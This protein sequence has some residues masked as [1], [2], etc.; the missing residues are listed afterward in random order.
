M[1]LRHAQHTS[2]KRRPR[3]L[4]PSGQRCACVHR[5]ASTP[6]KHPCFLT[7]TGLSLLSTTEGGRVL[8]ACTWKLTGQTNLDRTGSDPMGSLPVSVPISLQAILCAAATDHDH[9]YELL[10]LKVAI[11]QMSARHI[12]QHTRKRS[13]GTRK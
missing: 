6:Q 13:A 7:K 2:E 8:G 10:W 12:S 11:C 3:R 1:W 5:A 9:P 4:P